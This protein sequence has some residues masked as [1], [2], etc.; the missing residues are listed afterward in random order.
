M[1]ESTDTNW[2]QASIVPNHLSIEHIL[3]MNRRKPF[4]MRE[5]KKCKIISF[6][7]VIDFVLQIENYQ[8][9][10]SSSCKSLDIQ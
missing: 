5:G 10:K 1:N 2:Q 7:S 8:T 3:T 4:L 9:T 6:D